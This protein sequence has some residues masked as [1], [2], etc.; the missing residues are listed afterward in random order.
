MKE[1]SHTLSFLPSLQLSQFRKE[2]EGSNF[3]S[4]F[5]PSSFHEC[6]SGSRSRS[7]LQLRGTAF[8]FPHSRKRR[9]YP[10]FQQISILASAATKKTSKSS[11]FLRSSHSHA[12][13]AMMAGSWSRCQRIFTQEWKTWVLSPQTAS[14]YQCCE[15]A[16]ASILGAQWEMGEKSPFRL[17]SAT[18]S[19]REEISLFLLFPRKSHAFDQC[20]LGRYF[21]TEDALLIHRAKHAWIVRSWQ[22][23][24]LSLGAEKARQAASQRSIQFSLPRRDRGK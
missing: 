15:M 10:Y 4:F 16:V 3:S 1:E 23:N 20:L 17:L 12:I 24:E 14:K 13:N 6:S 21:L 2:K 9:K 11:L 7:Q 18:S 19:T 8:L 22:R 5:F